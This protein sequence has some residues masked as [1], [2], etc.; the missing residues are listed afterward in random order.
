[1]VQDSNANLVRTAVSE[2][3]ELAARGLGRR[4]IARRAGLGQ[5]TVYGILKGQHGI[6]P[7]RAQQVVAAQITQRTVTIEQPDGTAIRGEP[8]TGRE[9]SRIAKFANAEKRARRGDFSALDDPDFR[10]PVLMIVDGKRMR[11]RL[12]TDPRFIEELAM[13]EDDVVN[14][15]ESESP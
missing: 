12:P 15:A 14:F 6:G 11:V 1:M 10:R 9:A 5:A 7:A 8:A 2:I 13:R 3:R 4:E